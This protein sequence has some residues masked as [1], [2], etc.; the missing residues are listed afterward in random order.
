MNAQFIDP[1]RPRHW[2]MQRSRA[3]GGVFVEYGVHN[4]D[5]AMWFGGPITHVV[6]HGLTL[7][8]TRPTSEGEVAE[9]DTD[10]ACSWIATY[11]NG[12][13]ALFRAG[14]A[15]LPVGGGGMRLYGSRGSLAWQPDPTGRRSEQLI[16]ATLEKPEPEVLFEFAP[17]FDPQ[18][19]AGD[20]PLGLLARYTT[21]LIE[22][23]VNDI[24]VGQASGPTFEDGLAAQ[25]V[26]AAIR[27]SLDEK[28]W[29]EVET[30]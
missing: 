7:V 18:L 13:E 27:M 23:F 26:L 28:R 17:P 1:R 16:G 11:A 20:F 21:R 12:G 22:S 10:D 19:D 25:R 3:N 30:E 29:V 9:I 6:A 14:W 2:K 8:P 5:L 24:Q 4:I 15:S